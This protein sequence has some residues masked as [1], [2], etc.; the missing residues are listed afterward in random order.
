MIRDIFIEVAYLAASKFKLIG[1][2]AATQFDSHMQL[3]AA[4]QTPKAAAV[5]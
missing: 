2:P 3:V 1:L 4:T 5:K